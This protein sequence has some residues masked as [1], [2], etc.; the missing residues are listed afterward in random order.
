MMNDIQPFFT[1]IKRQGIDF[2]AGVPDSLLKD[3]CAYITDHTTAD[4]HVITANEGNAVALAAGHFLGSGRYGLVYMQN[5]GIG[6]AINPLMSLTDPEVY[7]IPMLVIVGW[8]GEPGV[9]DEPQHVKQGRIMPSILKSL[10]IP[11]FEIDAKSSNIEDVIDDACSLMKDRSMPVVIMVR[12]G[13]FSTYPMRTLSEVD[14]VLSREDAI[15]QI[16][17]N[18]QPADLVVSTTGMASRELNEYRIKRGEGNG[19][20][21]LTVGSMGHTVSIAA[22][23]ARSQPKHQVICLDGDGSVIMHMGALA[24]TGQSGL[25]NLIHIVLNN[26]AHGSVGGQPTVGFKV[27]LPTIATS[28]GYEM[29]S[30]VSELNQITS[31][32]ARLRQSDGPSFLEIK[33][34]KNFRDN[35]SRPKTTP[36]Q[37]RDAFMARLK[38]E[39]EPV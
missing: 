26:G 28:C 6:N 13:S 37:N 20:D 23:V 18:L 2:F 14:F 38:L 1:A 27:D 25:S 39:S 10:E 32:L 9:K 12:K 15:C 16:V 30:S 11:W 5:S 29:V 34:N 21:F 4:E 8:R 35:L 36:L 17:D 24:V 19:Y 31:E 33:L 22:G 3:F 7:S